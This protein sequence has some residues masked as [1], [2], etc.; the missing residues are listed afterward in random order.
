MCVGPRIDTYDRENPAG[1]GRLR[2]NLSTILVSRIFFYEL[3][4]HYFLII[5]FLFL[6][7]YRVDF[8]QSY[9]WQERKLLLAT[10]IVHCGDILSRAIKHAGF[11]NNN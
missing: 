7:S 11:R 3:F 1:S 9:R 4:L 6:V 8:C 10:L 5:I 2:S